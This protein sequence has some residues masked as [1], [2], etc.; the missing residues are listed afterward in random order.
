MTT[1]PERDQIEMFVDGVFR[2]AS[3]QG[4]REAKHDAA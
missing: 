4:M 2:Y 3:P 1:Q